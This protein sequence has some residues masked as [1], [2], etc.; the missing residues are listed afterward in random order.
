MVVPVTAKNFKKIVY[1]EK[2]DVFLNVFASWY[3]FQNHIIFLGVII[4][5][6]QLQFG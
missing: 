1:D 2:K 5:L 6:T 4:P 3:Y